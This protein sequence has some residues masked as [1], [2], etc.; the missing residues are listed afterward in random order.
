MLAAR[1]LRPD[2]HFTSAIRS[3]LLTLALIGAACPLASAAGPVQLDSVA[4]RAYNIPAG[5]LGATLS[6]FAVGAGIALSF[7]P[8]L[9]EGLSSPALTGNYTTQEAVNRLLAGSG[10]D[11]VLRSDGTYTWCNAE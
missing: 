8:S 3:A 9:T 1:R 2:H 6:S 5:P 11:M 4:I 7:Q 10:L